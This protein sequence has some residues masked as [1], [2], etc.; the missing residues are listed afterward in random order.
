MNTGR[1]ALLSLALSYQSGADRQTRRKTQSKASSSE[2]RN[3]GT[4]RS[5]SVTERGRSPAGPE[6]VE[7]RSRS[8]EEPEAGK[9]T[10]RQSLGLRR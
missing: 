3:P 9:G 5:S 2:V 1:K 10:R 7:G 4:D 6:P 8:R